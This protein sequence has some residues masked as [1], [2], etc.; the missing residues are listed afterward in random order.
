MVLS[1]STAFFLGCPT[2]AFVFGVLVRRTGERLRP[3]KALRAFWVGTT[4]VYA[5]FSEDHALMQALYDDP[6]ST[7]TVDDA[8]EI[9]F[10]EMWS[11]GDLEEPLGLMLSKARAPGLLAGVF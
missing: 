2:A 4:D 9:A 7:H 6:G 3:E 11:E 1:F 8:A 5:A 10:A